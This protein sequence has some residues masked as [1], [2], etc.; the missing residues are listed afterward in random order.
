MYTTTLFP[1]PQ[2]E[3][4]SLYQAGTISLFSIQVGFERLWKY[5]V[6]AV[7]SDTLRWMKYPRTPHRFVPVLDVSE[8]QANGSNLNHWIYLVI[9]EVQMKDIKWALAN[10]PDV[11][12]RTMWFN[13]HVWFKPAY[14]WFYFGGN[15]DR[16][17]HNADIVSEI[18]PWMRKGER[19]GS[20]DDFINPEEEK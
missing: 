19:V 5:G 3:R 9:D 17:R 4:D 7:T 14:T 16:R 15:F 11:F 18:F 12:L 8:F 10:R 2:A 13:A 20:W 1:I 6:P